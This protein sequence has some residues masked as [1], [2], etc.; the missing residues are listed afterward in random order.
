MIV[1]LTEEASMTPVLKKVMQVIRPESIEGLD[2][3]II[4]HRGKADLAQSLVRKMREWNYRNPHFLILHDNDRGDCYQLKEKLLQLASQA[5]KPYH[6][7]IVCQELEAWFIGDLHAVERAFP[8]SSATNQ[9][10]REPFRNPDFVTQPSEV[11]TKFTGTTAKVG[12]AEK[13]SNFLNLETNRSPSFQLL[14][15]TIKKLCS[16]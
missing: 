9:A 16:H 7:R 6:V 11:I 15:S 10:G 4:S 2:W 3:I 5:N 1:F 14:I 13:I 8:S 12:R